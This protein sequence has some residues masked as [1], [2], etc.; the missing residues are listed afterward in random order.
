MFSHAQYT[1]GRCTDTT[2]PL[3][4]IHYNCVVWYML[5]KRS[6][7]QE[8][9]PTSTDNRHGESSHAPRAAASVLGITRCWPP[10]PVALFTL[11]VLTLQFHLMN[12]QLP[13]SYCINLCFLTHT[14][15]LVSAFPH[16]SER[17][18]SI[19]VTS[20]VYD[21]Q[22]PEAEAQLTPTPR[23][24]PDIIIRQRPRKIIPNKL[25]RFRS[26]WDIC[27]IYVICWQKFPT[28]AGL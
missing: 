12:N 20:C 22:V 18:V 1:W 13:P 9:D 27:F 15:S 23:A 7:L 2:C 24:E 26:V 16:S 11:A 4:V 10:F 28:V 6:Y 14:L 21:T 8:P 17:C 5:G 25:S 3:P 19:G